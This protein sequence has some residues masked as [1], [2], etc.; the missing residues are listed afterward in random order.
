MYEKRYYILYA[1]TVLS[2]GVQAVERGCELRKWI[3]L[4]Y[5]SMSLTNIYDVEEM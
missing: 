4:S 2:S 1:F 3:T 5:V